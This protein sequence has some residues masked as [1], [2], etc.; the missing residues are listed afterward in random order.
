HAKHL[1]MAGSLFVDGPGEL[2]RGE[3]F[4]TERRETDQRINPNNQGFQRR[5][6][7]RGDLLRYYGRLVESYG[8]TSARH[9]FSL[10]LRAI[11]SVWLRMRESLSR[12]P[13]KR[14]T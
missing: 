8:K 6:P 14:R 9:Y 4:D 7:N 3:L 11:K 2:R 12:S 13:V 5:S 1:F 10:T